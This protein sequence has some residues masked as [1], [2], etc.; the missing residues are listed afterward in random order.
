MERGRLRATIGMRYARLDPI[1]EE[2]AMDGRVKIEED[3]GNNYIAARC[4]FLM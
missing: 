3:N 4:R 1:S 2:L